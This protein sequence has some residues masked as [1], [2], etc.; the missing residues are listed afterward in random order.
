MPQELLADALEQ[1]S[2]SVAPVR[3][4]ALLH[5]ARVLTAFDQR[6]AER[7]LEEGLATLAVLPAADRVAIEPQ[8]RCLIAT[9][10]PRRAFTFASARAELHTGTD[11]FLFDMM[12]HGHVHEAVEYLRDGTLQAGESFP[13]A[14]AME[15]SG[16]TVDDGA[17][18]DI[19]RRATRAARADTQHGVGAADF[20]SL[21]QFG[22][23]LL[24]AEEAK[25]GI[26]EIVRRILEQP[27]ERMTGS[28][29]FGASSVTISSTRSFRLFEIFGPLRQ[30][31][32][33]LAEAILQNDRQLAVAVQ[34]FPDGPD[35]DPA[36]PTDTP[37]V[38]P[39]QFEEWARQNDY[40]VTSARWIP[41]AEALQTSF[42][43]AF[44]DA[45]YLYSL[46]T[47][48]DQPNKVPQE[49]WPSTEEFRNILFKAGRHEGRAATRHLDRVPDPALRLFAQIELA[50][51]LAQLPQ[52]GGITLFF[53]NE[54]PWSV[55]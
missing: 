38:T 20:V 2:R 17:R 7:V 44:E 47:S 8:A 19:L 12:R 51:A 39:Q 42:A 33:Q 49:C 31:D 11:K 23:K 6:R 9:V 48:P 53:A 13:Y 16:H 46:D 25:T 21:F 3:A 52:L 5:A 1:A 28:Y 55:A 32:P 27:D 34:T 24:P 41:I 45:L 10:S 35:V 22:W 15:A 29:G 30:L 26:Q 14:A 4:A 18:L 43:G 37:P 36:P 54:Y 50:A 40:I